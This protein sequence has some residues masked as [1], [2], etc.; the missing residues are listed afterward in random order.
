MPNYRPGLGDDPGR[1]IDA[2]HGWCEYRLTPGDC[3]EIVH[4]EVEERYRNLGIGTSLF[5]AVEALPGLRA[6]Y[7]FSA[8]ENERIRGLYRRMG[9][10][11]VFLFNFYGR[12]RHGWIHTKELQ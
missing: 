4:M 1:R 3:A 8:D 7:T 6:V 11:S 9:Y 12:G 5:A 10:L 2:A